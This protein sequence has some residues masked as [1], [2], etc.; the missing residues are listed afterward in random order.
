MVALMAACHRGL[1]Y[2]AV[3]SLPAHPPR[4]LASPVSCRVCPA[5]RARVLVVHVT[6]PRRDSTLCSVGSGGF[7]QTPTT[8]DTAVGGYPGAA[9]LRHFPAAGDSG[10]ASQRG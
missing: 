5:R 4:R 2:R 8:Y 1:D 7:H 6:R 3:P 10:R 9:L